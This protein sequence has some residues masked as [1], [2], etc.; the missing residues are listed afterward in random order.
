MY[1]EIDDVP[2][3]ISIS[4][5]GN[6]L[7][8]QNIWALN[9]SDNYICINTKTHLIEGLDSNYNKTGNLYNS[10]ITSG[11]FSLLPVGQN[12]I[13][14]SVPWNTIKFNYLYY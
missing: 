5:N 9:D 14:S 10:F 1:Y 4:I 8:I 11:D 3:D 7:N 6:L 12:T 2:Q 13:I